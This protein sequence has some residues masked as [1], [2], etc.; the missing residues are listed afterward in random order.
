MGRKALD[1]KGVQETVVC[2]NE[3]EKNFKQSFL[4]N[5][6]NNENSTKY[7]FLQLVN[8]YYFG[9]VPKND[10][11]AEVQDKGK[12]SSIS[13]LHKE[14]LKIQ[15]KND[16]S[17][18]NTESTPDNDISFIFVYNK[19][20]NT[21]SSANNGNGSNNKYAGF[22]KELRSALND[23]LYINNKKMRKT[24]TATQQKMCATVDDFLDSV[25]KKYNK[26][27]KTNRIQKSNTSS[28][29]TGDNLKTI[30]E[31]EI[32][33]IFSKEVVAN[34]IIGSRND[35]QSLYNT[36]LE[37]DKKAKDEQKKKE[38]K[39]FLENTKIVADF[40]V[41]DAE[42]TLYCKTDNNPVSLED[43]LSKIKN[44]FTQDNKAK[45]KELVI[46][47]PNIEVNN[48]NDES[49]DK[50]HEKI[51]ITEQLLKPFKSYNLNKLVLDNTICD[52]DSRERQIMSVDYAVLKQY[53]VYLKGFLFHMAENIGEK[54]YKDYTIKPYVRI[55]NI[56][57]KYNNDTLVHTYLQIGNDKYERIDFTVK[58][59]IDL[60]DEADKVNNA[61]QYNNWCNHFSQQCTEA[62]NRDVKVSYAVL[63]KNNTVL[64]LHKDESVRF[65]DI[66]KVQNAEY[67]KILGVQDKGNTVLPLNVDIVNKLTETLGVKKVIVADTVKNIKADTFTKDNVSDVYFMSNKVGEVQDTWKLAEGTAIADED[68]IKV[69]VSKKQV[70]ADNMQEYV[71]YK[72]KA[73]NCLYKNN[74]IDALVKD[75]IFR[76]TP[77]KVDTKEISLLKNTSNRSFWSRV[78]RWFGKFAD[79]VT[80]GLAA[81]VV[82]PVIA[83]GTAGGNLLAVAV[84][85]GFGLCVGKQVAKMVS[86]KY[87]GIFLEDKADKFYKK[88]KKTTQLLQYNA[89]RQEKMAQLIKSDT[90]KSNWRAKEM[91]ELNAENEKLLKK[92]G[93]YD[94]AYDKAYAKFEKN[95]LDSS[96]SKEND[97]DNGL[98]KAYD[99]I[100]DNM[101]EWRKIY[102]PSD[103]KLNKKGEAQ[104]IIQYLTENPIKTEE[105]NVNNDSTSGGGENKNTKGA[106]AVN[107]IKQYV[108]N[109]KAIKFV[110]KNNNN[111]NNNNDQNKNDDVNNN[112]VGDNNI[113]KDN[114]K[115]IDQNNINKDNGD[116]NQEKD[117]D[118]DKDG[119]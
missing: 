108:E 58:Q 35:L 63:D 21:E 26:N 109:L 103:A 106:N 119:K 10:G 30:T 118:K 5:N 17:S 82:I 62:R 49:N 3:I 36:A 76:L 43:I 67:V 101:A 113:D 77:H 7:S 13:S 110:E 57:V 89:N 20:N 34:A 55:M 24:L 46:Y 64:S 29:N 88:F 94:K 12:R 59:L 38:K 2:F 104:K 74:K 27:N 19:N 37:A 115:D 16:E 83:V 22:E 75:H 6:N 99:V 47:R 81:C 98:S 117:K 102:S 8:Y 39:E 54:K 69:H 40:K 97:Q 42:D 11:E 85:V 41:K 33:K 70:T 111:N 71:G 87:N 91:V 14:L 65:G 56:P 114:T 4:E 105:S 1:N 53:D 95:D 51:H 44:A 80:I 107:V 68:G 116:I 96:L 28:S 32:K 93:K 79:W 72:A 45:A 66:K 92:L 60:Q 86:K 78:G 84:G 18:K 73:F 23:F 50:N 48:E 100:K 61:T 90:E 15:H 31:D 52:G 9:E 25:I 112:F